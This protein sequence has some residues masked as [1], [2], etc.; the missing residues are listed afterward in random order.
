MVHF[1]CGTFEMERR[2]HTFIFYDYLPSDVVTEHPCKDFFN[3]SQSH[4]VVSETIRIKMFI[5]FVCH[6]NYR[7]YFQLSGTFH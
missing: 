5:L 6:S 2:I 1:E 7:A 4:Y 3:D